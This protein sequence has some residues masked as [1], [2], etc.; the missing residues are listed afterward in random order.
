MNIFPN[1][2]NYY[3]LIFTISALSILTALYIEF[4][5]L[6]KPCKLCIYQRLPYIAAIL[7]SL[8]GYYYYKNDKI[9]V[10]NIIIFSLS[11]LISG[12][13]FG[14][15]NNF[16]NEFSGC[17]NNSLEILDKTKLL[18]NINKIMPTNCKD[19]NFNIFGFSLATINA[20][21]SMFIIILSTRTL[22]YETNK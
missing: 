14:I 22:V 18:E 16:F 8:I 9:L 12:Y 21:I 10:L 20:I 7:S 5:L 1:R 17:S 15:E 2:K 3:I 11:F 13:H 4:I 19:V 6:H